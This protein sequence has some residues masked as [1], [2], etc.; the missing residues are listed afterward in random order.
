LSAT[1]IAGPLLSFVGIVVLIVGGV[2]LF[3][4]RRRARREKKF[5]E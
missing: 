3:I 4:D 5:Q 2:I 1:A